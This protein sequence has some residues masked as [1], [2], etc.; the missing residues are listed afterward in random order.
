MFTKY[1]F[2]IS[3]LK[4]KLAKLEQEKI[5]KP[6]NYIVIQLSSNDVVKCWGDDNY[7]LL[8]AKILDKTDYEIVVFDWEHRSKFELKHKRIHDCIGNSLFFNLST[9]KNAKL[10]TLSII[11]AP[12]YKFLQNPCS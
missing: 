10:L 11:I 5:N 3:P 6:Q 8:C 1:F 9:I 2:I 4:I 12:I 7:A